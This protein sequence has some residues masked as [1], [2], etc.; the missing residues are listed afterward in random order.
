MSENKGVLEIDVKIGIG[1][2]G[3]GVKILSNLDLSFLRPF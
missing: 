1:V 3:R 2:W